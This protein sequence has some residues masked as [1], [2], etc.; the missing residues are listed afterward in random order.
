MV[1]CGSHLCMSVY[2][3]SVYIVCVIEYCSITAQVNTTIY[4]NGNE[5]TRMAM[6][7]KVGEFIKTKEMWEAYIEQLELYFEANNIDQVEKKQAGFL[8]LCGPPTYKLV[9]N[10][11]PQ[12]KPA[13]VSYADLVVLLRST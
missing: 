10:L 2:L 8:T 11:V 1:V 12:K 4:D 5:N 7:G 13:E 3:L 6:Q 9:H